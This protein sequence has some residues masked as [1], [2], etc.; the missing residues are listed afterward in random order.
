MPACGLALGSTLSI[1]TTRAGRA[2]RAGSPGRPVS[3]AMGTGTVVVGAVVVVLVLVVVVVGGGSSPPPAVR[4]RPT[5]PTTT[6]AETTPA[7]MRFFFES[8]TW[9]STVCE[10]LL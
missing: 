9:A 3:G 5:P 7:A 8:R 4:A 10:V 1:F 6:R 2:R